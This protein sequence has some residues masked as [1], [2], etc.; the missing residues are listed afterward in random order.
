M[1]AA[2]AARYDFRGSFPVDRASRTPELLYVK[3]TDPTKVIVF[4]GIASG[5]RLARVIPESGRIDSEKYADEF[6][7]H[8]GSSLI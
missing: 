1:C 4:A 7:E 5:H 3:C 8:Q 2:Y 6:I